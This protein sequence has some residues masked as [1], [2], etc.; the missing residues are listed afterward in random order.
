VRVPEEGA[1]T[2]IAGGGENGY[3]GDGG[4]ATAARMWA[5][6]GARFSPDGT[7]VIADTYN[8]RV[9]AVD[10]GGLIRTIAGDGGPAKDGT[11]STLV[12]PEQGLQDPTALAV[13]ANGVLYIADSGTH[14]IY[15]LTKHTA[16]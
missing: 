7:L 14:R 3:F 15:R 9:R 12:G 5:P 1:V 6:R 10:H 16:R 8:H 13:D 4:P 11:I 2:L